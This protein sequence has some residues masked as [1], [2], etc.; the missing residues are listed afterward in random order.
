MVSFIKKMNCNDIAAPVQNGSGD[1]D[2]SFAETNF[3]ADFAAVNE[4]NINPCIMQY[5]T[6]QLHSR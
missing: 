6:K 4:E 5:T 3:A 1:A 2:I